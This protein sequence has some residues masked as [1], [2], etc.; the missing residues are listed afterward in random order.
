V[1]SLP[2][3]IPRTRIEESVHLIFVSLRSKL[4]VNFAL[5]RIF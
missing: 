1:Y 4:L 5:H 2:Q 3:S